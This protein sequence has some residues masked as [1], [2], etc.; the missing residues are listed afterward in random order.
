MSDENETGPSDVPSL[1][2]GRVALFGFLLIVDFILAA[3]MLTTDKNLQTNF[4]A[5]APYYLHWYGVLALGV[6]DLLFALAVLAAS[7]FPAL[8]RKASSVGR[9][10]VM[11]ALAWSV[12][13]LIATLGIVAT[14]GQ[15]GFASASEFAKYLFGVTAYPGALSYIPWLYDLTV[16]AYVLTAVAG[17]VASRLSVP[18]AP[19]P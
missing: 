6:V 3:V 7:S 16:V 14:Y 15:V 19:T 18:A 17:A 11:V 12:L 8:K 1:S 10:L 13:V 5:Q 4:G 9:R 2:Q